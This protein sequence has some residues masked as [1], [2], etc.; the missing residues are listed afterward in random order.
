MSDCGNIRILINQRLDNELNQS[1]QKQLEEHLQE[2]HS[3]KIYS[4]NMI[5]IHNQL[6]SLPTIDMQTSIVDQLIFDIDNIDINKKVKNTKLLN[7]QW[8][9]RYGLAIAAAIVLF[10]PITITVNN[11]FNLT[12]DSDIS[13]SSRAPQEESAMD[14]TQIAGDSVSNVEEVGGN[15]EKMTLTAAPFIPYLVEIKNNQLIVYQNDEVIYESKPWSDDLIV[16]Y[17]QV[18]ENEMIYSLLSKD[19]VLVA[20]YKINLLEKTEEKLEE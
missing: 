12:N 17:Y 3:C 8:M 4:Q 20:S 2:C 1:E 19:N 16:D 7:K 15:N 5:G 18:N 6:L 11:N 9:K 13:Y 10:V 14:S